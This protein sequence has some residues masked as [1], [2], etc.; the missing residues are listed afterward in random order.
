M[1]HVPVY[2]QND[3]RCAR[4]E[5]EKAGAEKRDSTTKSDELNLVNDT[6]EKDLKKLCIKKQVLTYNQI[7]SGG[8]MTVLCL[9]WPVSKFK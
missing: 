3:I 1:F 9:Q 6:M 7:Q 2:F 8:K 5:N 4:K